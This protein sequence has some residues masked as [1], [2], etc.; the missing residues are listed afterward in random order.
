M[1]GITD[2]L[3]EEYKALYFFAGQLAT[4]LAGVAAKFADLE[5]GDTTP[6]REW[7]KPPQQDEQLPFELELADGDCV[8]AIPPPQDGQQAVSEAVYSFQGHQ[9]LTATYDAH[10]ALEETRNAG[11]IV[12]CRK[13]G[14]YT[15]ACL[16]ERSRPT[17]LLEECRGK[18]GGQGLANQRARLRK[19]RHPAYSV[20]LKAAGAFTPWQAIIPEQWVCPASISSLQEH[21]KVQVQQLSRQ[22]LLSAFGLNEEALA[23][24]R[25]LA[26][27]NVG[28]E[29]VDETFDEENF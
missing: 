23:Q 24:L 27:K 3:A 14:A 1:H 9:L 13:C 4:Y 18:R 6:T 26:S 16:G 15:S 20:P 5:Q 12:Y 11:A 29:L 10:D 2:E 19:A 22:A 8:R 7:T 25:C 21:Q 17:A 28:A